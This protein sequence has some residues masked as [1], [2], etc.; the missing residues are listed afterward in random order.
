MK[1]W[2]FFLLCSNLVF[3]DSVSNLKNKMKKIDSEIQKKNSRIEKIDSEK[4]S[5]QRQIEKINQDIKEINSE[6]EKIKDEIVIVN[7]NIQYGSINLDVSNQVLERKKSEFKAKMI[8]VNRL[9]N[10]STTN[11]DKSVAKRSF[12]RWLYGDLESMK[13]I[14]NV[15]GSIEGVKKDIEQDKLKLVNLKRKLDRNRAEISRKI[16][17]KKRLVIKLNSEK[18]SH[19]RSI[20]KLKKERANLA[21]EIE[22]IIKARSTT[23]KPVK[24]HTAA[25]KLGKFM[26][27]VSGTKVVEFKSRKNE[28]VISNGIEIRAKMGSKIKA[29]MSGKVI[30]ADKFQGF[31]NVVMIDHGYNTISVYGN[32]IGVGVRLNQKVLKGQDIGVLGL[33]TEGAPNLYYEVRFN[34]KPINPESLF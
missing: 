28:E 15:K 30:Y 20:S 10:L 34:L 24:L 32:L 29:A 27:P 21:K 33:T 13:H 9:A 1:R 3:G 7:R 8:G 22:R 16:E 4:V 6:T 17:E 23:S 11:M 31:N 19:V 2:I 14:K 26:R 5:I 12:S 18:N 25:L